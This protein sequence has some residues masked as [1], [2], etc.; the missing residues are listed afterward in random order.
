[1]EKPYKSIFSESRRDFDPHEIHG[2][3]ED[4]FVEEL[5]S[6]LDEYEAE[7]G[8]M[9]KVRPGK[10][11]AEIKFSSPEDARNFPAYLHKNFGFTVHDK[12]ITV[13][14]NVVTIDYDYEEPDG[15]L[16]VWDRQKGR[17]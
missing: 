6:F 13:S 14:K 5:K 11:F 9:G 16:S 4:Q 7:T 8:A 12:D 17:R 2:T 15:R 3:A 1:M 10:D